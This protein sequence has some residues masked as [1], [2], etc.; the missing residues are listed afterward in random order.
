M[1]RVLLVTVFFIRFSRVLRARFIAIK[2][3]RMIAIITL[4]L[5]LFSANNKIICDPGVVEPTESESDAYSQPE[6]WSSMLQEWTIK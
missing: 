6:V 5:L 1:H 2:M 3:I 4:T